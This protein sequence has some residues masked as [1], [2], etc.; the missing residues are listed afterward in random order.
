MGM[1]PRFFRD[2]PIWGASSGI[3]QTVDDSTPESLRSS[4]NLTISIGDDAEPLGFLELSEG[5]DF[6]SQAVKTAGRAFL[7]AALGA[8]AVAVL[9][10]LL[11]GRRLTSPLIGLAA[12]A[13]AMGRQDWSERADVRGED[14]IGQLADQ[15]N[16]MAD[17][18]ESSFKEL[19][20]ERD[21]L[22]RFIQDASHELRTPLTALVT[23]NELLESKAGRDP[24]TREEFVKESRVELDKLSWIIRD[25]LDLT[26]LDAGIHSFDIESRS[27]RYRWG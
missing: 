21:A 3:S 26:R 1:S 15:F 24:K 22:R 7:L 17:S 8:T 6:S 11:M 12:A 9:V 27:R 20:R 25:L 10:G 18:L 2:A 16:L 4:R 5:P 19:A 13:R 23:F 14:E